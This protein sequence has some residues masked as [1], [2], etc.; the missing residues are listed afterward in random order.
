MLP[1]N[2]EVG[3]LATED[4]DKPAALGTLELAENKWLSRTLYLAQENPVDKN[5]RVLERDRRLDLRSL[6]E[7]AVY[8]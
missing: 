6:R 5:Y 3:T 4:S 1:P 8:R 7:A 2:R